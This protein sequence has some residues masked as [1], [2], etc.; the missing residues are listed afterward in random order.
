MANPSLTWL[1]R[2]ARVRSNSINLAVVTT[3]IMKR[4]MQRFAVYLVA[5]PA[6][7]YQWW[8]DDMDT[9]QPGVP[10]LAGAGGMLLREEDVGAMVKGQF[11]ASAITTPTQVVY[12]ELHYQ[13]H[14]YALY[15]RMMHE[16]I[17]QF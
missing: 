17:S 13:Q 10:M 3:L 5:P 4:S 11:W 16:F 14:E 8:V 15:E 6:N 2:N 12:F 7:G 1:R 9:T